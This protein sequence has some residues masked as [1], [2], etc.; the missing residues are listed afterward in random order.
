M[1]LMYKLKFFT[2]NIEEKISQTLLSAQTI[3][4]YLIV[5][6]NS[7]FLSNTKQVKSLLIYTHTHLI[8]SKAETKNHCGSYHI[9]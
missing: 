1:T 7:V 9:S 6:V 5:H 2:L 4:F 8:I 3:D